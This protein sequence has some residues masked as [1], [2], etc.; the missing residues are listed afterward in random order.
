MEKRILLL[1]VIFMGV[2]LLSSAALALP[3]IGPP[4]SGLDKD[5]FSA[6]FEYGYSDMDLE[7]TYKLEAEAPTV[8]ASFSF[9]E[10]INI[11]DF[12]NN[13][14]FGN[15]GYGITDNWDVFVRLGAADL[16]IED[17]LEFGNGFAYGFGTKM[18][19]AETDALTWGGLF[20][21]TFF[22]PDDEGVSIDEDLGGGDSMTASGDLE[23][24]WWEIQIAVGPTWQMNDSI[25]IYGGP[26]FHF[27]DGDAEGKYTGTANIGGTDYPA[28][29]KESVDFEED[30]MFGGFVGAQFDLAENASFCVEYQLTGDASAF[31]TGIVWRF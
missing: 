31:S 11:E 4:K 13:M 18:T 3:P 8:P 19:F 14:Y 17:E 28:S 9:K 12:K 20:Q 10:K 6:G 25:C 29:A 24:D 7:G 22:N 23:L 26:F 1:V 27:V 16:E 2:G 5:Q 30:S 15:L 21:M